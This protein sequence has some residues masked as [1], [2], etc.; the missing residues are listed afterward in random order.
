LLQITYI[1]VCF[2][3]IFPLNAAVEE[4]RG[5]TQNLKFVLLVY[6]ILSSLLQVK[7][8]ELCYLLVVGKIN[9]WAEIEAD[10]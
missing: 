3:A 8:D 7:Y 5:T 4:V 1:E 2:S 10:Q 6:W 9:A